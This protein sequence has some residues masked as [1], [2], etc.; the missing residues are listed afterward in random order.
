MMVMNIG[1]SD[2]DGGGVCIYVCERDRL[3]MIY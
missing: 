3:Y 2:G 1:S